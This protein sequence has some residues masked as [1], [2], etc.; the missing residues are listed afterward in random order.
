MFRNLTKYQEKVSEVVKEMHEEVGSDDFTSA[1]DN[2]KK[3][4]KTAIN[5]LEGIISYMSPSVIDRKN[6]NELVYE[7]NGTKL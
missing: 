5:A 2:H 6:D 7:R 4:M 1:D 3:K